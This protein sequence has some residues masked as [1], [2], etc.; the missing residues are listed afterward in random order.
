MSQEWLARAA[1]AGVDP[2]LFFPPAETGPARARQEA[3]AKAVCARC[4]V[5][6]ECREWALVALP[7][8]VAGGLSEDERRALRATRRGAAA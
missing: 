6:A 8:G 2:E 1:C 5:T 3:A 7:F 4:P